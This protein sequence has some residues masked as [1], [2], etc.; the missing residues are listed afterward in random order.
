MTRCP[1]GWLITSRSKWL[2]LRTREERPN[3]L[4]QN[5][6][7]KQF[8]H[9]GSTVLSYPPVAGHLKALNPFSEPWPPLIQRLSIHFTMAY[10][11][12]EIRR[13]TSS[14]ERWSFGSI[15]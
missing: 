13:R 10:V 14:R 15:L 8:Y 7:F 3:P 5:A 1:A 4:P 12:I 6:V 9:F 2:L 11:W